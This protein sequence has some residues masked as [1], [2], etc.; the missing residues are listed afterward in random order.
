MSLQQFAENIACARAGMG[1]N[2]IDWTNTVYEPDGPKITDGKPDHLEHNGDRIDIE[3]V[4][5]GGSWYFGDR[6]LRCADRHSMNA[7]HRGN[8]IGMRLV[9]DISSIQKSESAE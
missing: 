7:N 3:M 9:R 4:Y 2:I 6:F 8:L 1:G 5:K